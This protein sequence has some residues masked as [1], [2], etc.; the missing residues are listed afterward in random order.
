MIV[1]NRLR[2][3]RE[4]NGI[5][6]LE[7]SKKIGMMPAAV[8]LM[9]KHSRNITIE[10]ALIICKLFNCSLDYLFC[11]ENHS[12]ILK[13]YDTKTLKKILEILDETI[14]NRP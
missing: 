3:I 4:K 11:H 9:E 6:A 1:D 12:D 7:L 13:D 8:S 2:E 10:K 5:T 14:K